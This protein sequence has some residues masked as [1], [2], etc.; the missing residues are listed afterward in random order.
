MNWAIEARRQL[1]LIPEAGYEEFKT[2]ATLEQLIRSLDSPRVHI[3]HWR[4]GL[5][6]RVDGLVGEKTI[7][8]RAD[9][10][11]L[12]ITEETGLEFASI[13]EGMMHACGHDVHMSIALGLIKRAVEVPFNHHLVVFFQPAEEGPGGAEPMAKSELFY[14]FRPDALF[15]LHVAPEYPVGMVASR[16][17]VLFASARELH[18]TIHGKGGH[19]AFP[20]AGIDAIIV[21][22]AL[23]MQLQ[24]IVSRNIDPMGSA[25]VSIGKVT[26]G[27]KENIIADTAKLDGTVRALSDKEMVVLES[28]IR[29]IIA[30]VEMTYNVQIDLEFGNRYHEVVN[31]E[32]YLYQFEE[33][34]EEV[35]YSYKTCVPAMTGEDFGYMLKQV[36]GF[37]VWLGV[38]DMGSGLHQS[39]LN[40][41]ERAIEVAIDLFDHYFRTVMIQ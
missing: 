3:T 41:D 18:I 20:H 1:H 17:G 31:D 2:Q 5:F 14:H 4:T 32:R 33:A 28:R 6:V 13:H 11:G 39:T 26:A 25:V 40:P 10:D 35:G 34:V 7:G 23:I 12:P 9:M 8:Y 36:P 30:G 27:T 38:N 24:T 21:Q 15:G 16:P 29:Q 37:M 19:G 22:A